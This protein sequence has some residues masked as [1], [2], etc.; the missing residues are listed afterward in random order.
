MSHVKRTDYSDVT[1]FSLD[2]EFDLTNLEKLN[3][4]YAEA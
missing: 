4:S 2:T 3:L 1:S